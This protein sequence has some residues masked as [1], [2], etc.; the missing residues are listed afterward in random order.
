[1]IKKVWMILLL[2]ILFAA[3]IRAEETGIKIKADARVEL[4][5]LIFKLAGAQEYNRCKLPEYDNEVKQYFSK[6]QDHSVIKMA[7]T[8][9]EDGVCFDAVMSMAVHLNNTVELKLIVPPENAVE[10]DK[11]WPREQIPEFLGKVRD[12]VQA[13]NFNEFFDRHQVF[14]QAAENSLTQIIANT[15]IVP[16]IDQYI[17]QTNVFRL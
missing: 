6:F 10:L 3:V 17:G 11:R 2:C 12:F 4:M 13:S 14:Y 15:G 8:L 9:R 7:A 16:W 5:S 1:M